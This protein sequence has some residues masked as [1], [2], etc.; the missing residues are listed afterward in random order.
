MEVEDE[1]RPDVVGAGGGVAGR[2]VQHEGP[3]HLAQVGVAHRDGD[4]AGVAGVGLVRH[5]AAAG[6]RGPAFS[7]N[8]K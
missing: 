8:R 5:L 2:Q 4:A 7:A 1:G 3:L 6:G